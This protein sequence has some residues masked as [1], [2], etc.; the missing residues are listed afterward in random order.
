MLDKPIKVPFVPAQGRSQ[1]L[2]QVE[3]PKRRNK[4]FELVT[5]F[6]HIENDQTDSLLF[7]SSEV[8]GFHIETYMVEAKASRPLHGYVPAYEGS[9]H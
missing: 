6:F 8:R 2:Y 4:K 9:N 5:L 3:A 7:E 1:R